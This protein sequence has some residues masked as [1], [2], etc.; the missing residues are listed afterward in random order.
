MNFF[1]AFFAT[2]GG[3]LLSKISGFVRDIFIA[4]YLGSGFFSD[5]FFMA[6]KI[7]N[8]FRKITAEG[9]MSSAFIPMFS[10]GVNVYGRKRM[11]YFAR[12]IFSILLYALL[13]FVIFAEL[14]MPQFV[15]LFAFGYQNEKLKFTILLTKISFPYLI[16]ISLVALMTGIL[17]TFGKFFMTAALP[18]VMNLTIVAFI[19]MGTKLNQNSISILASFGVLFAGLFQFVLIYFFT[20]KEKIYLFPIKPHFSYQTK[21]FFKN[22]LHTFLASGVVQINS[23]VSSMIATVIPGAVSLLYYSDRISQLPLSLIGTAI[24]VSVL[25]SLSK[26]LGKKDRDESQLLQETSFFFALFLGIPIAVAL[27]IL[28]TPITALIFE[29][30]QFSTIDTVNVASIIRIYSMAIPFYILS[31]I[32]EAIFYAQKDTVTPYRIALL[33]LLLNI[34]F[35]AIFIVLF[36]T[37]GIAMASVL[38]SVFCT[39]LFF[40]KLIKKRM[41]VITDNIYLKFLKIIYIAILTGLIMFLVGMLMERL[42]LNDFWNIFFTGGIG[43]S[44]YLVASQLL[45]VVN[46]LELLIFLRKKR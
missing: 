37:K 19:I 4:K 6:F 39:F 7:P 24:S 11:T 3:T 17:N 1:K 16:F 25:P 18:L 21:R 29:R 40:I 42:R 35:S 34:V 23:L 22:F 20:I 15:S 36:E 5:V 43:A 32:L 13:F 44:F 8:F 30:G 38:T 12:N 26:A 28:S 10:N 41:F 14:F 9:A 31:K 27:F 33:N 46:I 2:S 45:G